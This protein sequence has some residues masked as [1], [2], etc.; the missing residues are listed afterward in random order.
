MAGVKHDEKK[1]R[2]DLVPA[3]VILDVAEVFTLGA[4]KYGERN[5]QKGIV[6]S[7]VYAAVQRHLLTWWSL[8]STDRESGRSHLCHALA[9]LFMLRWYERVFDPSGLNP[10]DDRVEEPEGPTM[11]EPVHPVQEERS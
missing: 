2:P 6:Y 4:Q 10:W 3:S 7:R 11:T 5:W 1:V 9:G 8:Q